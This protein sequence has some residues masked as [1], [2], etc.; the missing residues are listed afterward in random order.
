[1]EKLA[2]R[3]FL[4]LIDVA[5]LGRAVSIRVNLR[6]SAVRFFSV[7]S[8]SLADVAK[9]GDEAKSALWR[10]F[11]L[12]FASSRE[13]TRV[14][15]RPEDRISFDGYRFFVRAVGLASGSSLI[16]G[17]S[18]GVTPSDCAGSILL[19]WRGMYPA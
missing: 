18:C 16:Q 7:L 2:L 17:D 4:L 15:A 10:M 8:V 14:F 3:K 5:F 13:R 9:G 1:M 11:L 19:E 6:P 12:E